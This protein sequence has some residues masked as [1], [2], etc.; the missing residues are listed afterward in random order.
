[1]VVE[2]LKLEKEFY[3]A[4]L[5]DRVTNGPM[6]VCSAEGGMD[7][8]TVARDSPNS[9]LKQPIDIF[10][11]LS[12]ETAMDMA[13]KLNFGPLTEKAADEMLKLYKLFLEVLCGNT[14]VLRAIFHSRLALFD[15]DRRNHG[16]N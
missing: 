15:A 3:F 14:E 2:E 8:E 7:I 13:K 1:M 11:G 10:E 9:I 6:L 5:M 12:K 16:G 4:I